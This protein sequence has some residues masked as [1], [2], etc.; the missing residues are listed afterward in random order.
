MCSGRNGAVRVMFCVT[1]ILVMAGCGF[2]TGDWS[3]GLPIGEREPR[4]Q[5][6]FAYPGDGLKAGV[7]PPG[8]TWTPN[9]NA[10]AYR[11]EVR[12]SGGGVVLATD[13]LKSTVYAHS[14]PLTPGEYQWQVV[15]LGEGNQMSAV[16]NTRRFTVTPELA[17]L[18]MPEVGTLKKQLANVRPRIFLTGKREQE[19]K[20]AI[21]AG[22]VKWWKPF[23]QAA[24]DATREKEYA[25]PAGYSGGTFSAAEWRRIFTPGKV[26]SAHVART[27]LAYRLTGEEKY[28]DA[29][30]RWLLTLASWNPRGITSHGVQQADGSKGNDEASMPILDRMAL[31]WDWVG[32]KLSEEDRQKILASMTERGNQVLALL[33][34]QD[35]LTHPFSNHEG[36]V[37]AFLGNAGLAFLGDI[38]DAERWLDYVLRCYLTSYPGWGGDEGG[39]A[40]GMSYWSGYVYYHTS[41]ADALR[42][43]T[44]VNLFR[45]PFYRNT[46][47][48]AVYF[49][50]PYASRG[51][52]GDG[53]ERGPSEGQRVLLERF[54]EVLDDP[55]LRWQAQ[56]IPPEAGA[57]TTTRWRE[58]AMEDVGAVLSARS[59]RGTREVRPPKDLDGSRHFSDIGWVAMHSALGDPEDDVWALFKSSRFGSFSHSHADQNT[60]QLNAYGRPLLIDSGYYPWM[61]SAHDQ[62]WTRQTQAHNGILVN[63]R[64]QP[65]GT[66]AANG[67]IEQ[68]ERHGVVTVVR[69]QA[70]T[71]YNLPL[72]EG[73]KRLWL[74]TL[75][76]RPIPP[77]SPKVDTFERT[78]AFVGSKAR[79]ALI[80]HDYLRTAEPT[81]FDW[82]LHA[83]NQMETDS[84][85]GTIFVRDGGARLVVRVLSDRGLSISQTD[86]F[87][88]APEIQGSSCADNPKD[89][90]A[91]YAKQWHLSA[92]TKAPSEQVRF[93]AIMVP[94]RDSEPQ[95]KIEDLESADAVGFRVGGTQVVSWWGAGASGKIAAGG[96][97]GEGRLIVKVEENGRISEVVSR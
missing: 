10:K 26:G 63:G 24:D 14:T 54:A 37:L 43:A 84:R 77:M 5:E 40:Q 35:F 62:L 75:N 96:L 94:Y 86:R 71:A 46:G 87:T 41:F 16:S 55:V 79:P 57:S 39:W 80:V 60:F 27:A 49:Q 83:L 3:A 2:D 82:L 12:R 76:H 53:A 45:R 69:G 64:G 28:L 8:F 4:P 32:D 17:E 56:S 67:N 93:L 90:A 33:Q 85:T 23:I 95:P 13:P 1:L 70:A 15:Y 34:Q 50:P 31:G 25:E 19:I 11:L 66:W 18:P 58:W 91:R 81:T 21:K 52:F 6:L 30:R 20:G 68:Y 78:L 44:G 59:G 89:C 38:P 29:A 51:A 36:R 48:M 61:G 47:Y 73:V 42:G 74:K 92:R 88:V 22:D 9:D 97:R 7:N 72:S 65:P